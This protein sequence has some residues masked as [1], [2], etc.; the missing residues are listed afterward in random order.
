MDLNELT[1]TVALAFMAYRRETNLEIKPEWLE[2]RI[3]P[4]DLEDISLSAKALYLDPARL[5]SAEG[6]LGIPFIRDSE[7]ERGHPKLRSTWELT[8]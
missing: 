2:L 5:L 8:L 7:V 6:P 3:H 1:R 4:D